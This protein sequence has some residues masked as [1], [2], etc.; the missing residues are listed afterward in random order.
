MQTVHGVLLFVYA[1]HHL[2]GFLCK[3]LAY[4]HTRIVIVGTNKNHNGI[5][6]VA[7]LLVALIRLSWNIVPLASA[8]PIYVRL[9]IQPIG[10]I[11]PILYFRT[12]VTRV[13]NR[14]AKVSH[15]LTLPRMCKN[16]LRQSLDGKSSTQQHHHQS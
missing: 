16:G 15:T 9:D 14:V 12:I 4:G 6:A 13:G 11:A 10:Q 5:N 2:L 3:P 8:H 7:M 1:S